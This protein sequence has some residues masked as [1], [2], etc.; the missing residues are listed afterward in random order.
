MHITVH[1]YAY[2]RRYLPDAG[3]RAQGR[4]DWDVPSSATVGQILEKLKLP[5]QISVTVLVN[6]NSVDREAILKEGDIVH[7]LPQMGG[8]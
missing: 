3:Q 2:L 7:I 4:A 1:I 6:G 5:K 8:G